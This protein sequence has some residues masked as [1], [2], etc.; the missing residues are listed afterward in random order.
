LKLVIASLIVF[1]FV[2]LFLFA[3][4]PAD[5]SVSRV[6]QIRSS[7]ENIQK[8]IADLREWKA[9]NEMLPSEVE[10]G[11]SLSDKTEP[12]YISKGA[13]IIE[14]LKVSQDT[15]ITRWK[16][17]RRT[18]TGN[19]VLT[20]MNGE[21]VLEWTLYFHLNWYPWEKLASMFYDKQLGPLMENSLMKLR[22]KL[23]THQ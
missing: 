3:L 19:F 4:F 10:Q 20:K 5:L 7:A 15:V 8:E 17:G 12:D 13:T 1:S 9:W 11:S 21:V 2:I 22:N 16:D 14:V 6:I 23:E 18:F